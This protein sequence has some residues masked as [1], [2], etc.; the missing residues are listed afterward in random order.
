MAEK[1][2]DLEISRSGWNKPKLV[3]AEI[4]IELDFQSEPVGTCPICKS[5]MLDVL[6]DITIIKLRDENGVNI[7][8]GTIIYNLAEPE[9]EK[10]CRPF[11]IKCN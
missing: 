8:K 1:R 3:T 5:D 7:A 4:D 6:G 2:I 9:I 11:C 10:R